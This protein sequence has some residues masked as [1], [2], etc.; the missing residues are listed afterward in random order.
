MHRC[1]CGYV[2]LYACRYVCAY[3]CMYARMY[4]CMC[5]CMYVYAYVCNFHLNPRDACTHT[6]IHAHTI[7]RCS[8]PKLGG[9][10]NKIMYV[11]MCVCVCL[12]E[13]VNARVCVLYT[14]PPEPTGCV[15]LG[16]NIRIIAYTPTLLVDPCIC[17]DC[18]SPRHESARGS[19]KECAGV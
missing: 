7:M 11:C 12:D 14:Y 10:Q 9:E 13:C 19:K 15:K 16:G 2:C 4:V 18:L 3:V 1:L 5:V 6:H 17:F 8:P